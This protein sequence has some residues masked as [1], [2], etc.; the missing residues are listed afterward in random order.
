M[1]RLGPRSDTQLQIPD[2]AHSAT[3][4]ISPPAARIQAIT[5]QSLGDPSELR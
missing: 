2:P 4:K 5:R 3:K 1:L